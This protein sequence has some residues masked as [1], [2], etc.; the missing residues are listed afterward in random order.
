KE[1][2]SRH[3]CLIKHISNQRLMYFKSGFHLFGFFFSISSIS[4]FSLIAAS[5]PILFRLI[6]ME[7]NLSRW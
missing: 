7:W 2:A 6:G 1:D 3:F 4:T 5:F